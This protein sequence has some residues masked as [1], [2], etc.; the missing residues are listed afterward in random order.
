MSVVV[1]LLIGYG[2]QAIA[3]DYLAQSMGSVLPS[4]SAKPWIDCN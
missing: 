1:G 2:L 3:T 4:A